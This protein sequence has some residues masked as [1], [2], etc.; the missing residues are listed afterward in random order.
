MPTPALPL[1][2]ILVALSAC[3]GTDPRFPSLAIRDV[4]RN[5]GSFTSGAVPPPPVP[6]VATAAEIAVIIESAQALDA[7]FAREQGE[8]RRIIDAARGLEVESNNYGRAAIAFAELSAISSRSAI[9]LGDLDALVAQAA[10]T[11]APRDVLEAAQNEAED[12]V[13]GQRRILAELDAV[14]V[15]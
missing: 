4:E 10:S 2:I 3:A 8:V 11:G 13:I 7:R 1:L 12:I 6:P 14:L 15:R 5:A 9:L